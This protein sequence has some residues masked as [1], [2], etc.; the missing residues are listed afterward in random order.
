MITSIGAGF[1]SMLFSSQSFS[2]FPFWKLFNYHWMAGKKASI[3][4]RPRLKW[5]LAYLH[6]LFWRA[7]FFPANQGF[8]KTFQIALIGWKK[9]G[10]PEKPLLFWSCKQA[11]CEPANRDSTSIVYF[12]FWQLQCGVGWDISNIFRKR[13]ALE[14]RSTWFDI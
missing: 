12:W 4:S 14:Q 11:T 6:W 2:F 8:L 9:I 10:S 13:G 3:E 1:L 7:G 5:S